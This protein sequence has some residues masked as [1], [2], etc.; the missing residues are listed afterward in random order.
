MTLDSRKVRREHAEWDGYTGYTGS[1]ERNEQE[2]RR[3]GNIQAL[4]LEMTSPRDLRT[5]ADLDRVKSHQ[6]APPPRVAAAPRLP[7]QRQFALS[8][9]RFPLP[10][11]PHRPSPLPSSRAQQRRVASYYARV[12]CCLA[13]PLLLLL[14]LLL[15][16]LRASSLHR[17]VASEHPVPSAFVSERASERLCV[18]ATFVI[19][20]REREKRG[21]TSR[22][23]PGTLVLRCLLV[24]RHYRRII[25]SEFAIVYEEESFLV[26]DRHNA[27]HGDNAY[28]NTK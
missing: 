14:L 4:P 21:K 25:D 16:R 22:S 28:F 20:E 12:L 17:P 8:A 7:A 6:R 10:P 27:M 19:G 2:E 5:E 26:I 9:C 18:Y 24:I 3:R 23:L 13:F 15:L 11:P 1:R